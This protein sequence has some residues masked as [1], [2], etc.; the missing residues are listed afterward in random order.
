M[1]IYYKLGWVF[2]LCNPALHY[3]KNFAEKNDDLLKKKQIKEENIMYIDMGN[4]KM[5][6][7]PV[8][9]VY[10]FS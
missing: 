4:K 1:I 6:L 7:Q 5:Y 10:H 3:S 8:N 9:K 2:I